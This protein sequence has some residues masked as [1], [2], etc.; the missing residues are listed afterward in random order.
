MTFPWKSWNELNND[1]DRGLLRLEQ[2]LRSLTAPQIV[3][4]ATVGILLLFYLNP[5]KPT[6]S[7]APVHGRRWRWEPT[8]WLQS[9]FTFNSREIISSG[10]AKYKDCPFVVKRYDVNFTVLPHRYLEELGLVPES[11]LS[12]AKAQAQNG[13]HKWTGSTV[14]AESNLH[15]RAL[16]KLTNDLSKHLVIAKTELDSAW[17]LHLPSPKD[18]HEFDIQ[19]AMR[20]LVARMS[21]SAFVGYPACRN[22]EWLKISVDFTSD[23]FISAFTIRLFPTWVHPIVARL[24][25]ARYRIAKHV[26]SASRILEPLVERHA[27]IVRRKKAGEN[28]SEEDT[29]LNW[30]IDNGPNDENTAY[31]LTM[32]QLL[33]TVVSIHT[34]TATLANALFDL[35]TYPEWIP[36]LREEV[37][38]VTKEL[39]PIGSRPESSNMKQWL[40]RLGKLDSFLIESQRMSPILLL[41][42]QREVLGS[43]TLGDGTHI[44]KGSRICWAGSSHTNDPSITPNPELF[45]PMRSYLK[46]HSSPDQINKHIAGQTSPD[47]LSFGYGKAACP[48]RQF[49]VHE[50]KMLIAR[51]ITEYDFKFPDSQ[52]SRPKTIDADEF[53]FTDPKAKL[54]MRLR[55]G[56]DD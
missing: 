4:I 18:W 14:F 28:V 21:A 24:I 1:S 20:M 35:C 39:G 36:V 30:M 55:Q 56:D 50:I 9:R 44:P 11:K 52:N 34:T 29:L 17:L 6:I 23:F 31:K 5:E 51:L 37:E 15:I 8:L 26:R 53:T 2:L 32:R 10:Y 7:G 48:G 22:E 49:A 42:P 12:A 27:D 40:R 25:P 46:R 47:N 16:Q 41:G 3:A 54:M 38:S 13:G 45:D 43:L 19:E 33:L